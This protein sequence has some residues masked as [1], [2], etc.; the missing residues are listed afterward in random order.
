MI[1]FVSANEGFIELFAGADTCVARVNTKE[2]IAKVIKMYG[3]DN[4]A[5]FTSSMDF[6][7]EEGFESDDSA[8]ILFNE[9]VDLVAK[10]V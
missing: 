3:I 4:G 5:Y 7:S 8:K 6:A 9:G 10:N 1:K 2:S